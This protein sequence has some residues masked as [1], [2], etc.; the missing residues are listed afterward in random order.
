[1]ADDTP[2]KRKHN[3]IHSMNMTN[4]SK[5]TKHTAKKSSI[6]FNSSSLSKVPFLQSM[7]VTNDHEKSYTQKHRRNNSNLMTKSFRDDK[8]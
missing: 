8:K 5:S 4:T 3:R 1:M 2:V 6:D 7:N